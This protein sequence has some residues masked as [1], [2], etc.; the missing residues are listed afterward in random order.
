MTR[1][2]LIVIE[3]I[4]CAGKDTQISCLIL[5]LERQ[6][7]NIQVIREPGGTDIGESL[8]AILKN[9]QYQGVIQPVTSLLLFN[10][11]RL[12]LMHE[13]VRPALERGWMV[14]S[15]RSFLSTLAY[16]GYAEGL[17][18]PMTRQVCEL[19]LAGLQPDRIFLL[20][21]SV[22]EMVRRMKLRGG[23]QADRYDSRDT[24]FHQK[25]REGY[26]LE[27]A[28]NPRLVE[29]INGERPEE[30]VTQDLLQRIKP[31]LAQGDQG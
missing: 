12:Q 27:A 26:Q 25:V 5:W 22:E 20:D 11:A 1:G 15:N 2:K 16:Q 9:P 28:L 29:L 24:S 23:A 3:G 13:Q 6:G 4:E 10:A 18:L 19:G 14:V 30:E 21:I 17:A 31:L 8:R 7:F